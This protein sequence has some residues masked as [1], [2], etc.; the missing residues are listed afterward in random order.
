MSE[1]C[2]VAEAYH[3][4]P[5][6]ECKME[7]TGGIVPLCRWHYRGGRGLFRVGI[8]EFL[9]AWT[10]EQKYR[11]LFNREHQVSRSV[12]AGTDEVF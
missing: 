9:N 2:A 8:V 5:V 3:F 10:V 11:E 6:A 7:V 4:G 1:G 12:L